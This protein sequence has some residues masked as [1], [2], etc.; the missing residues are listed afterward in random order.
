MPQKYIKHFFLRV[1]YQLREYFGIYPKSYYILLNNSGVFLFSLGIGRQK[2][3]VRTLN[4]KPNDLLRTLELFIIELNNCPEYFGQPVTVLTGGSLCFYRVEPLSKNGQSDIAKL[5]DWIEYSDSIIKIRHI[6]CRNGKRLIYYSGISKA[7]FNNIQKILGQKGIPVEDFIPTSLII[8]EN[9]I[10]KNIDKQ[11]VIKL[12]GQVTWLA[13]N[14]KVT[15]LEKEF[16]GEHINAPEEILSSGESEYL[17][18]SMLATP[19]CYSFHDQDLK[20]K[21]ASTRPLFKLFTQSFFL[22]N[23]RKMFFG[24]SKG[25]FAGLSTPIISAFRIAALAITGLAIIFAILA[26]PIH[27]LRNRYDGLM[28][29]YQ[30]ESYQKSELQIAISTLESKLQ[31][32]SFRQKILFA[33]A[34]SAFCQERPS[35]LYLKEMAV[36]HDQQNN[37]Y[38]QTDGFSDKENI[39][40][41]YIK[42]ISGYTGNRPIEI[43]QLKKVPI[44]N[45][46]PAQ[47]EKHL[48][49]FRIKLSLG[50]KDE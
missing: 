49:G 2:L 43:T 8:L 25:K 13:I 9:C 11:I 7:L 28:N 31:E 39:V 33:G 10:A 22:L 45:L 1:R 19:E 50:S 30:T 16:D 47:P 20:S 15:L 14:D 37:F 3:I 21:N 36:L 18:N 6:K 44:Q 32:N 46:A 48:Y 17:Q 42:E 38:L 4:Q 41:D 26:L 5:F 29:N 12:P 24:S 27:L 35:G 23:Q 34:L 40:F